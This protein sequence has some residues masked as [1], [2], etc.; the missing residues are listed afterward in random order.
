MRQE[1][2]NFLFRII[3]TD[4]EGID[5]VIQDYMPFNRLKRDCLDGPIRVQ[6]CSQNPAPVI[7]QIR[8]WC[9]G[10]A[11]SLELLESEFF[12]PFIIQ[13]VKAIL[14]A[15]Y[16]SLHQAMQMVAGISRVK[17]RFFDNLR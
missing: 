4:S 17:T 10:A 7:F 8:F 16:A 15:Y 14:Y 11:F 6:V 1:H 13:F 5:Q 9:V 12:K 3:Y 2:I